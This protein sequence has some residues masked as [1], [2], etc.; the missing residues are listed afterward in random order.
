MDDRTTEGSLGL[1]GGCGGPE[2]GWAAGGEDALAGGLAVVGEGGE[3]LLDA[4]A[5]VVAVEE[6]AELGS[7]QAV[8]G[9]GQGGVDLVGERVAGRVVERPGGASGG[10]VV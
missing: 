8:G 7:G 4:G 3:G 2:L 5:G 9:V 10:V 6:V 1:S